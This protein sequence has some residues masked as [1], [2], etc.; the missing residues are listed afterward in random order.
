MHLDQ[1]TAAAAATTPT[2]AMEQQQQEEGPRAAAIVE[3][4][5]LVGGHPEHHNGSRKDDLWDSGNNT[6]EARGM[7]EG[8][9]KLDSPMEQPTL[10]DQQ[11]GRAGNPLT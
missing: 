3:Q 11:A 10:W 5:H 7:E 6:K 9:D 1:V 2:T 4:L 8:K